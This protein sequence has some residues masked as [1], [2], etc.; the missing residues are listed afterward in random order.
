MYRCTI[1]IAVLA[2]SASSLFAQDLTVTGHRA[3]VLQERNPGPQDRAAIVGT[4]FTYQGYLEASGAPA[5]GVYDLRFTLYNSDGVL[6]AGPICHDNVTVTDGQFTVALDF[7]AQYTGVALFLDI[8]VRAGGAVGDCA[9][10]AY[11]A[12]SPRQALTPA[13]YAMGLRLP[14]VGQGDVDGGPVVSVTNANA[15]A[16]SSS[17]RGVYVGPSVFGFID[18]AGIRGE[19]NVYPGAGVL[20][21]SDLY[22]G[23]V[24]YSYGDG[25]YGTFGRADGLGATGVWGWATNTDGVGAW[26]LASSANGVGVKGTSYDVTNGWG[27]YFEGRGYFSDN[28]GIGTA[29]PTAKLEVIGTVKSG[30]LQMTSGA[31]AGHVLTSDAAG[32]GIWKTTPGGVVYANFTSGPSNTPSAINQFLSPTLTVTISAG[33]KIVVIANRAF[34]TTSAGGAGNLDLYIGYRDA[35]SGAAPTNYGGGMFNLT[36]VQN[37][38]TAFGISGVIAGLSAGTYEVGMT[39]D[40]DGNGQWNNNEWGYITVMVIN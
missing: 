4:A 1:A 22:V 25:R 19:S 21:I 23:V 20:G 39:G 17:M 40:D 16:S 35:G 36:A 34:G 15:G 18:R 12:L 37:E 14:Y 7:G 2:A 27:G 8:G 26:G 5:N 9:V 31:V 13:P 32:N 38:R 28:V 33:Q 10:G 6:V 3:P 24:G 30:G 29:S 11:T